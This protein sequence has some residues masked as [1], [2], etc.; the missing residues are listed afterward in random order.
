MTISCCCSYQCQIESIKLKE[1]TKQISRLGILL[2][3]GLLAAG[4]ALAVT[5][6]LP[7]SA[8]I[9]MMA[10]GALLIIANLFK[11]YSCHKVEREHH[12]RNGALI[13]VSVSRSEF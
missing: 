10:T 3:A 1:N 8:T 7:I 4:I 11:C 12:G 2:A 5:N 9:P 6:K 13:D